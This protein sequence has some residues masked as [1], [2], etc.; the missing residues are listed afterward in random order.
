MNKLRT[1]LKFGWLLPVL[2][3]SACASLPSV[4]S[5]PQ[6]VGQLFPSIAIPTRTPF[7]PLRPTPTPTITP[8]PTPIPFQGMYAWLDPAL[9]PA[10][11]SALRLP[12]DT[13]MVQDPDKAN[14]TIGALRG[15]G[16]L[17]TSTWVYTAAAAFPTLT[18]EVSLTELQRAWQGEPGQTF[19]GPLL[20][21]PE[22]R[23]AFTARWGPPAGD[24]LEVAPE[25]E[26]L[27]RA[28][29]DRSKWAL[30]PFEDIEPRW[31]VLRVD[32]RSPLQKDLRL[33]DYPLTVWFGVAGKPEALQHLDSWLKV[34]AP[35][36]TPTP[37]G[38]TPNPAETSTPSGQ[39]EAAQ[40]FPASNRDPG[41][42]T[43]LAMTG[44]T[45]LTRA[46]GYKMDTLGVTYPGRDIVDW[47][48]NADLTHISNEVSFRPDC[49]K[50]S[51]SDTSTSFCS[52][53]EYI[54]LLDFIG[55][56]IVELSGNH[57]NDQGRAAD[58]YSLDLYRKRG[59]AYFAGGADL[60]EAREPAR[61]TNNG[62]KLAFIGCNPA[63]PPGAWATADQPGA[64]PC[65]DY[66][67]LKSTIRQLRDEGY[68]P[69]VTFQYFE[70][71]SIHPDSAQIRDFRAA[72]D[73]GAV[74]VSGSQAHL[75]QTAEFY[76]GSFIHY[77]LGNLFFDQMDNPVTGTRREFVD[78]HIFYDG[79]YIQT[80]LLTAMLEDWAR[81]RPMN[82]SEREKFLSDV[83]S[84]S[85]W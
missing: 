46:T 8:S 55:T 58:S 78:H 81:P 57:N 53:P 84:A 47:L 13:R 62:N 34:G 21:S 35:P 19:D 79:R 26:L 65:G 9:P 3:A 50:A 7:Q 82:D 14:L 49:P 70:S 17:P 22:T 45:A 4:K 73:A 83:F 43:I 23:A 36:S 5:L 76:Q 25:N 6:Q 10:L 16:D 40:I 39:P 38:D 37:V 85:G 12:D 52:R 11:K 2:L 18:D 31:K 27:D 66:G 15:G 33:E 63:G 72:V 59:W 48:R 74:I 51:F 71:Y 60:N 56:D 68:L 61:I 1:L 80:E 29:K 69:I 67:W 41:K 54:E 28:W 75:P 24:R 77:G 44:V 30:I 64:A 20:L 32:G 42:M